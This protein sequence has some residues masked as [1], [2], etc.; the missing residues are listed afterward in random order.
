M[1]TG[2]AFCN[3]DAHLL[4]SVLLTGER[5][6]AHPPC[7]TAQSDFKAIIR[8]HCRNTVKTVKAG[9]RLMWSPYAD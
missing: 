5:T 9:I 7:A 2:S 6:P 1:L 3:E 8:D 4:Q